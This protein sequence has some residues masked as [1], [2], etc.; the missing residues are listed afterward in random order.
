[1]SRYYTEDFDQEMLDWLTKDRPERCQNIFPN[2]N[3]WTTEHRHLK[4]GT[5][6]DLWTSNENLDNY[7]KLS[8]SEFKKH[9]GM[10]E[11]S[12][13][14]YIKGF[15]R[16]LVARLGYSHIYD[17][18]DYQYLVYDQ[19]LITS[20]FTQTLLPVIKEKGTHLNLKQF[21]EMLNIE[22]KGENKMST[23]TKDDLKTGHLVVL[24][25]GDEYVVFKDS[26]SKYTTQSSVMIN[27][28]SMFDW[29]ALENYDY[30]LKASKSSVLDIME[31][32]LQS[33]PYSFVREYDK[34]NRQLL[35]ERE[36]KSEKDLQIEELQVTI[37][38]AQE[39]IN[40]LKEMK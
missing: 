13:V 7:T 12:K 10:P 25:N 36:E 28:D 4:L 29:T 37:T 20:Y 5:S 14:Y 22:T 9:I 3:W 30:T 27:L 34:D 6:G 2:T 40:K 35:W 16:E 15:D 18:F 38:Q 1:M 19:T 8:K 11:E 39:Q 32:Y 17:D 33:H 26:V 24:R 31:V 21:K 23:F